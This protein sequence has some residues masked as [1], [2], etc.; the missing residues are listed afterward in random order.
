M[1]I[2]GG[3]REVGLQQL[4]TAAEK[5]ELTH[6]E[7]KFYLAKDFSRPNE[8]KFA[9]SL[10]LFEQLASEYPHNPLWP[11]LVGSLQ[12]RLGHTPE[13]EDLYRKVLMNTAGE[14]TEAS[15]ALHRA[16]LTALRRR[17]PEEKF[18]STN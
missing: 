17:H 9:R 12:F 14:K 8:R 11:M 4:Q 3:R 13:G 7:A 1:A 6:G 16:A 10:E 5:G 15:A 18:E 2:P